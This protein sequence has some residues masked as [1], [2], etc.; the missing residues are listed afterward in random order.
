MKLDHILIRR[1]SGT[2]SG[3][4]SCA[5]SGVW[6]RAGNL[7]PWPVYEV[8]IYLDLDETPRQSASANT[9]SSAGRWS[10]NARINA[11]KQSEYTGVT[12]RS[13]HTE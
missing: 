5:G 4:G 1:S 10:V 12:T 7:Q 2:G 11:D 13:D 9:I 8:C 3:A 6:S